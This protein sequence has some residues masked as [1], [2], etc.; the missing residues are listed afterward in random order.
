M[1]LIFATYGVMIWCGIGGSIITP[2]IKAISAPSFF[3]KMTMKKL[4]GFAKIW[5]VLELTMKDT[6]ISS[7]NASTTIGMSGIKGSNSD[8]TQTDGCRMKKG[9]TSLMAWKTFQ[10]TFI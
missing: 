9:S 2:T 6:E 8:H 1:R 3:E 7:T 4:L 10:R 5:L